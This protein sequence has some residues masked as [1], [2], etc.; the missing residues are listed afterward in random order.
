MKDYK[1]ETLFCQA[2]S[3]Y[4]K[5]EM[6]DVYDAKRNALEYDGN[7]PVVCHPPCRL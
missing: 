3:A 2:D 4:K 5:R 6:W 7:A 1:F